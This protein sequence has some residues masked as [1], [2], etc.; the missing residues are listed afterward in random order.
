MWRGLSFLLPFLYAGYFYELYNAYA[1]YQLI[2]HPESE[3][4]V[5]SSHPTK[6]PIQFV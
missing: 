3:W 2:Y 1:L 4:Q 5:G 6:N